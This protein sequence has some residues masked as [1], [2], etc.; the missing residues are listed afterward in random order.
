[1]TDRI[2]H[3]ARGRPVPAITADQ[4]R[5]VDRAMVEDYGI[6]L[7]Q[8]MEHA[9]RHLAHLARSRFLNGKPRDSRIVV[10]AGRGGNGGGALVAARR[11]HGWGARVLALTV[12]EPDEYDGVGAHQI[13]ILRRLKV[14]VIAWD[15]ARRLRSPDL[16]LDGVIGYGLKGPP[17]GAAGEMI[18]WLNRVATPAVSLDLPSGLDATTGMPTEATA[19]AAA[20]LTLALPKTGFANPEAQRYLGDLYLADI[21][22]PSVLYGGPGLEVEVG[23]LF[24]AEDLVR[25]L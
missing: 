4:M 25:L 21:G 16:I 9:G 2:W 1:M 13:D 3:D 18:Q 15:P 11:L 10:L 24:D 20:T 22:V 14:P 12:V 5:E 8:M 19:L 23:E 7:I 17:G 6:E